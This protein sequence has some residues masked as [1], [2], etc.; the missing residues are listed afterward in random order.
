MAGSHSVNLK[1]LN[2]VDDPQE[3]QFSMIKFLSRFLLR[4]D[5]KNAYKRSIITCSYRV[6]KS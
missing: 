5:F 1:N 2:P 3:G 6:T 4:E